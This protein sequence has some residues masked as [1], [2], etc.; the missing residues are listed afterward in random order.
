MSSDFGRSSAHI[1]AGQSIYCMADTRSTVNIH[2]SR[3]SGHLEYTS[4]CIGAPNDLDGLKANTSA[5]ATMR[6][7]LKVTAD[8]LSYNCTCVVN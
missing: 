2:I 3:T 5:C 6:S 8:K 1:P 7:H 4:D